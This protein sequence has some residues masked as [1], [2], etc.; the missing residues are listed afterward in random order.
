MLEHDRLVGSLGPPVM[1]EDLRAWI[2]SGYRVMPKDDKR[3]LNQVRAVS[4]AQARLRK[5]IEATP[6]KDCR[7]VKA[8]KEIVEICS[9]TAPL[10]EPPE[11][12]LPTYALVTATMWRWLER[13][14]DSYVRDRI[15]TVRRDE[16]TLA[17]R[18]RAQY[19]AAAS[20]LTK[21]LGL[22]DDALKLYIALDG[23]LTG[24]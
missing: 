2:A 6:V 16:R 22:Q 23:E 18:E 15:E 3:T 14:A 19:V 13:Y 24:H 7:P 8:G 21:E 12:A 9:R 10:Q 4:D 5:Q 1:C 17:V 11:S 20:G